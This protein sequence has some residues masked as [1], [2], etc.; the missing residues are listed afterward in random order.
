MSERIN[1]FFDLLLLV[2]NRLPDLYHL[3]VE[4]ALFGLLLAGL[5]AL[6]KKHP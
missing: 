1:H 5:C 4:L 3:I 6:F 2:A